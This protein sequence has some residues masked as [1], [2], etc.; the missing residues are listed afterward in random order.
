MNFLIILGTLSG[1][2]NSTPGLTVTE[3]I[4]DSDVPQI[5]YAAVYPFG[6]VMIIIISQVMGMLI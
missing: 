1:G 3:T 6:L 4:T 5:A 2:M